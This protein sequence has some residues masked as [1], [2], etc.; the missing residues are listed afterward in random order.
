VKLTVEY[1]VKG[2]FVLKKAKDDGE[3]KDVKLPKTWAKRIGRKLAKRL[4]ECAG[5]DLGEAAFHSLPKSADY[6][7]DEGVTIKVKFVSAE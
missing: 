2:D 3:E 7:E 4:D 1:T 6:Y 5:E